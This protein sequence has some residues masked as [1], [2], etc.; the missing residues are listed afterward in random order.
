MEKRLVI[1]LPKELHERL[2][3]KALRESINVSQL[4]RN[5]LTDWVEEDPP[6]SEEKEP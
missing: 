2:R 6:K 4:I 1:R 5:W 3:E